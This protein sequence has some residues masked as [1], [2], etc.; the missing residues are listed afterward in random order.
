MKTRTY[1]YSKITFCLGLILLTASSCEREISDQAIPATFPTTPFIYTDAPVGLTDDFFISFDP[2]FGANTE[3]F[4]TDDNIAFE[5]TSSIRIDVPTPSDPNGN[6]IGGIFKDRGVGRDL[7]GYDALTFWA[8]G[9]VTATVEVGFGTDFEANQFPVSTRFQLSTDWRKITIPIPD[10]SRL[11]QEKGMFLFS[12]GSY[13]ILQNDN[14]SLGTSFDDNIGFT[15]WFD[16][17]QFEKL[18]TIGQPRPV[19]FNGVD[20]TTETFAGSTIQTT[21]VS[22]TANLASGVNQSVQLSTNYFTFSSSDT[23]IATVSE[24]GEITVLNEGE[25]TITAAIGNVDAVGSLT[26]TATGPFE[27]A[28]E[29]MRPAVNVSSIYSDTYTGVTSLNPGTFNGSGVQIATS[30]FAN[31]E[32]LIYGNLNFVG[33]GWDG[34]VDASSFTHVHVDVQLTSASDTSLIVELIDFGPNDT[35]NGL[36][37]TDDSA[38]GFNA[39]SQLREG[40]WVGIDIPLDQFTLR[41]GGGGSGSPNL[42]NIGYFVLVSNNGSFLIDNIYFYR[43]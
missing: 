40:Q 39:S 17:L 15:M 7:T 9:T 26:V 24:T 20:E 38:G 8:K 30:T 18:G 12:A 34:T 1:I 10:A 5:G 29:P 25:A 13:D 2:A 41:T 35:D 22:Y 16:E 37:G 21:G 27:N 6:F 42:S 4:G 19:I 33:I 36:R 11:T 43:D 3:G 31:N 23:N 14:P 32:H 28:P